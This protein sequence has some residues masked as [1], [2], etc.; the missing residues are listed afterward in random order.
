LSGNAAFHHKYTEDVE[1]IL[2]REP[3]FNPP[4]VGGNLNGVEA[5]AS[6]SMDKFAM[7]TLSTLTNLGLS[8]L[9]FLRNKLAPKF[10]NLSH[11]L[12]FRS[13]ISVLL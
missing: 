5:S 3:N 2:K 11:S 10:Q 8:F 13:Q 12:K 1:Q 6:V 9:K 7:S 4:V